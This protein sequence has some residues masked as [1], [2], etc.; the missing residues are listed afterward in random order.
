MTAYGELKKD[1]DLEEA[2]ARRIEFS[3][4]DSDCRGYLYRVAMMLT[5]LSLLVAGF[6]VAIDP[7]LRFG[8]PRYTGF[9][10]FKPKAIRQVRMAKAYGVVRNEYKTIFLG[11]SR[12]DIGLDPDSEGLPDAFKPAYNLGQP[13]GGTEIALAYLEHVIVHHKPSTVVLGVDF[14]NVLRKPGDSGQRSGTVAIKSTDESPM[15][16]RLRSLDETKKF[17]PGFPQRLTDA[18]ASTLSLSALSDSILT[19]LLQS[20]PYVAN[21]TDAGFNSGEAFRNLIRSEGQASLFEQKNA[22]YDDKCRE[23]IFPP[24][25]ESQEIRAIESLLRLCKRREIRIE[26]Y[27]HPYHADILRILNATDRWVEF[28][29]WKLK[30][31]QLC[32]DYDTRLWDF[33]WYNDSTTE[34]VPVPSDRETVMRWYWESG[35]YRSTLGDEL[36]ETLFDST[37]KKR[38]IGKVVSPETMPSWL[39]QI[40]DQRRAYESARP[41]SESNTSGYLSTS[42]QPIPSTRIIQ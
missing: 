19:V 22:E 29:N 26:V 35:H 15:W 40:R 34:A 6:N 20:N 18:T 31:S 8:I 27:T 12:V 42:T 28:E 32:Q 33:S 17:A 41:K 1:A 7:Y 23:R 21:M 37:Q 14:L 5:L 39:E 16:A 2:M 4:S 24:L 11:N 36:L 25:E 38:S 13:G 3:I 10:F 30:V 9:S